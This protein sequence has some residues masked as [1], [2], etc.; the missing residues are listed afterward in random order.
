MFDYSRFFKHPESFIKNIS[1]GKD[2]NKLLV[3]YANN[4]KNPT[5][6]YPLVS[7]EVAKKEARFTEQYLQ[8]SKNSD[9]VLR[10]NFWVNLLTKGVVPMLGISTFI[11]TSQVDNASAL[12]IASGAITATDFGCVLF[13]E[14]VV[15]PWKRKEFDTYTEFLEKASELEVASKID[16]NIAS[17]LSKNG[18][19]ALETQENLKR[20][21]L[22]ANKFNVFFMDKAKLSDLR[23]LLIQYNVYV[24]LSEPVEFIKQSPSKAKTRRRV[25]K[26]APEDYD[27]MD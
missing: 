4:S 8:V 6:S 25:K 20:R 11:F 12:M 24:G 2:N 10:G 15:K 1:F 16:D 7:K 22:V 21:G 9:I 17:G 27:D 23:E 3:T 19:K 18:I 26:Q 13:N 5:Q 14:L